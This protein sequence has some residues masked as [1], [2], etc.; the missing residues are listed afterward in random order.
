VTVAQFAEILRQSPYA[1]GISLNDL[2]WRA[3]RIAGMVED[4]NGQAAE[5]ARLI[6]T[7]A[8]LHE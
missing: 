4:E 1:Y 6:H 5:L 7:A 3:D 2:A 8:R